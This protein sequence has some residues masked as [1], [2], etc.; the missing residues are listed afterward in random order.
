MRRLLFLIAFLAAGFAFGAD[1]G[2]VIAGA[3][4]S[5]G[6]GIAWTNPGNITADDA[7]VAQCNL[8]N[9]ASSRYIYA[10]TFGIDIPSGAT[11]DGIEVRYQ[12][13]TCGG[14]C[15]AGTATENLVRLVKSDGSIDTGVNYSMGQDYTSSATNYDRGGASDLWGLSSGEYD[16]AD[17]E[18]ADFGFLIRVEETFDDTIEVYVDAMWIK[19]YYTAASSDGLYRFFFGSNL[20]AVPYDFHPCYAGLAGAGGAGLYRRRLRFIPG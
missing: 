20:E 18:D 8:T 17:V 19:I 14:G 12:V 13:Y 4:T 16:E 10:D 7:T 2:W 1:T 11:V 3:G 9:L 6:G 5:T 15:E